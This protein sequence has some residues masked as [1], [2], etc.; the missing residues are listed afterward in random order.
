MIR[1]RLKY[2]AVLIYA[3][4]DQGIPVT[5]NYTMGWVDASKWADLDRAIIE[6]IQTLIPA[7]GPIVVDCF[8]SQALEP[9]DGSRWIPLQEQV[10]RAWHGQDGYHY[11]N[12]GCEV[13][14]GEVADGI[15]PTLFPQQ[16]RMEPG[17]PGIK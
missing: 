16:F 5:A 4:P 10:F 17:C 9:D 3:L 7:Q 1:G 15:L 2:K 13:T 8:L 11:A 14:P 12:Y 6:H